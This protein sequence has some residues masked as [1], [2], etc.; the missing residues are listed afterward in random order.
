VVYAKPPFRGSEQVI[1]Y[2]ARYTHRVAISNHRIRRPAGGEV[3]FTYR[4]RAAGNMVREC[5]LSAEEFIRRF[6]LHVLPRGFMRI[7]HFG[8]LANRAKATDLPICRRLLGLSAEI[9]P[10]EPLDARETLLRLKGVDIALC[11]ECGGGTMQTIQIL[12]PPRFSVRRASRRRAP[13][14]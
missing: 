2:L 14:C 7:R 1:D 5:T 6:L 9:Q 11:P 3:T 4:D 8:F 12:H 10:P 13:P